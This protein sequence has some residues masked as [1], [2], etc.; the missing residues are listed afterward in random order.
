MARLAKLSAKI[1]E[2]VERNKPDIWAYQ[3]RVYP[4]TSGRPG[5][6]DPGL[7]PYI[8]PFEHALDSGEYKRCVLAMAAQSGK[9]EALLDVMGARL[10]QRPVPIL[11]AGPTAEFVKTQFE[12]RL[13]ELFEQSAT[14]QAK[15]L[16]DRMQ[17]K[18]LKRIAGVRVR[19]AHG[20]S[21]TA[22][23][24]DPAGLAV[25][26]E[27]DE[28][29]H[30]IRGQ[31]DPLGL[32]EARGE[33][34]DDF[35]VG[36][37]STPSLGL[38][39]TELDP[40][41]GLRFW[42]YREPDEIK[43]GIW[44]LWQEG[45]RHHWCWPCPH[46]GDFFVP[47]ADLLK[48]PKHESP[49]QVLH[50]A[51]LEC[52]GCGGVIEEHHKQEMNERG[53]YVAPGQTVNKAG[54]VAGSHPATTTISFWVSGLC[55]P[56]RTFGERAAR[57]LGEMATGDANKIQTVINSAFGECFSHLEVENAV[58]WKEV[59]GRKL[60]YPM[61]NVPLGAVILT[62][63]VDVQQ[64]RLVYVIRGWGSRGTSWLVDANEIW[65]PTHHN[66]VWEELYKVLTAERAGMLVS[67]AFID[68]GFRPN[69]KSSGDA[70]TVYDFCWKNSWLC[71]A[72]RG[73]HVRMKPLSI[74]E[75]GIDDGGLRRKIELVHVDSD[76]FKQWTHSAIRLPMDKPGAFLL[77]SNA[78]EDYCRQVA[79][80]NRIIDPDTGK[81]EWIVRS[82]ENHYLDAEALARAAA[83]L[84]N[85]H[86][87]PEGVERSGGVTEEDSH[88]GKSVGE[89]LRKRMAQ[90]ARKL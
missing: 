63:G 2:P 52:P 1:L 76:F 4:E 89:G 31:G 80:E 58:T 59:A 55:S 8:I 86:L 27:Y 82:S 85:C 9:T 14:L 53:V 56:F 88:S 39:E 65:G 23:K 25:V 49:A 74:V 10:D 26:D 3:N 66:D 41:S 30:N 28:M 44:K 84:L 47:R 19:L 54:T 15:L 79:A 72:T 51:Y 29:L 6:R 48:W 13:V 70:H 33:T 34:Y 69:K 22:L 75:H 5:A 24:S 67:K 50:S 40:N 62:A 77:P 17:S 57:L 7:T 21:S 43:S 36:V 68:A 83:W 60:P 61:G 35:S 71:R 78:T 73:H 32:V 11:Y 87:I 45:T 12:P 20:G 90:A 37:V 18:T 38:V 81:P 16:G 42:K 46:C 64:K